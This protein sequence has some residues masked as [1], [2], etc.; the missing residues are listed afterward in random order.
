LE[1]HASEILNLD[2][3]DAEAKKTITERVA[4][5][6]LPPDELWFDL[7]D[8]CRRSDKLN[9]VPADLDYAW[10]L[11]EALGRH[12]EFSAS[13]IIPTLSSKTD[14]SGKWIEL[15]AVRLAGELKLL[16]AIP[17]IV[18]LLQHG[19]DWIIEE[20]HR[21][22]VK[23]GGDPVV[24]Q[25]AR[26]YPSGSVDLRGSAASI[27]ENIHTDLSVETCLRL[28]E[29]EEDH[30]IR[31]SLIQSLLMNFAAD[32]IEPARHLILAMPLNPDIL[33]VRSDLLT[34][35]KVM[36][37]AFPEFDAWVEDA[38]HD[39]EFRRNWYRANPVF[40]DLLDLVE[41]SEE[42]VDDPVPAVSTIVRD[43][44]RVGRNDPCPC[45]SGKKYKKCCLGK[46]SSV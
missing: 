32:G 27:L 28:F 7:E 22:L 6:T 1:R 30:H 34:A 25:L 24:E 4:F 8:F 16:E 36:G 10:H 42:D 29:T 46:E 11:A 12:P 35:C 13:Q 39:T 26:A 15:F 19:D 23:I 9:E 40:R 3:L 43:Y 14:H 20:G 45:G 17:S 21:A 33:E 18:A 31:C 37:E 38:K 44:G 41:E 2:A 5:Q